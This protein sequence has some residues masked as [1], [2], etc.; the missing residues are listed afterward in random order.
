M[1]MPS[2]RVTIVAHRLVAVLDHV[3]H[4]TGMFLAVHFVTLASYG[5]TVESHRYGGA[6]YVTTIVELIIETYEIHHR[7]SP[8]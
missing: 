8:Y 3:E 7:C 5:A 1:P 6:N 4:E 2:N